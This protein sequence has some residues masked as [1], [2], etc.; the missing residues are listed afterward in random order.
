MRSSILP[1]L[2]SLSLSLLACDDSVRPDPQS[3]ST[4]TTTQTAQPSSTSSSTASALGSAAASSAP[5]STATPTASAPAVDPPATDAVT[6]LAQGSNAFGFDLYQRLQKEPGNLIISPASITTALA[7][8]W[9]GAKGETAA[10]MKKV[11]HFAGSADEV[12]ATS[13][14]LALSLESPNRPITFRIANQL[15]GEK[16]FKLE[17]PF[18]YKTKS[19]YGAPLELLDFKASAEDARGKINGWVAQKTEKRI[20]DLIPKNGVDT[21]TR[22]VLVNAIYFLGDWQDPFEKERTTPAAFSTTK[23]TKIDVPTMNQTAHYKHAKQDGV[24][25]IELPYKGGDMSMVIIVPDAV[26]GLGAV[27]KSLDAKKLDELVNS[28][29]GAK[30]W[31]SIP[32]FEIAPPASLSLG[33]HLKAMGMKSAFDSGKAD[34]TLIANPP[35]PADRLFIGKVFHKGFVKVDEK[36]TEAAAA[37]AVVMPRAGAAPSKP[38]EFKADRPFLFV[39]RDNASGLV[40]FMGRVV[41]PSKK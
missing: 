1:T 40:L 10:E 31:A 37:T 4:G 30:V 36:G 16:T 12:M 21:D 7:M 9:G 15:F 41:D 14:K 32:K 5:T 27:E 3:P 34:F 20:T 8:T 25:A 19:A 33:D 29:K 39:I 13:G 17:Q 26:D 18:L 24:Q 28:M 6:K 11:L 2:L 22:L 38:I 35:S 23:T